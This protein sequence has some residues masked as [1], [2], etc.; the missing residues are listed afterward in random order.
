MFTYDRI[1]LPQ[2]NTAMV[3]I[4]TLVREGLLIRDLATILHGLRKVRNKA[5]HENY[6]SVT[7][8][9]NFLPM[10]YGM[11]EWFMQTYGDWSYT[12]KNFV[13]PEER[14]MAV[15]ID[16]EAEEKKEAELAKQ[17]E[18]NAAN[19]P[20]VAQEERK[21]Q[22]Y[23]V[24]NQRPKTEAETEN[25]RYS[26]GIRPTRGRKLA[27]AEYP[28]NS[29]VG[30]RGYADY[31]LFIGEKLVGIIEA[32]AIHKDI[33]SVIDYQGK[34]YPRCIREEDEKYVIGKWGD[35]RVP[36]TFATNGRPYLEQYKTKSGIWFLDLRKLDNSPM[37]LHGWMSPDGMEELLAADVDSKNK[38]LKEMPYDL[39]TDTYCGASLY[40]LRGDYNLQQKMM[41]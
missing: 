22:A 7:D 24:A 31:A 13:M 9:K 16:K 18:E 41:V 25:I 26:K 8:S 29:T 11:C 2:D 5:V 34:D 27:I 1:A 3:R 32:K 15:S 19:A 33:P 38:E 14:A 35:F 17:A 39:L 21:K 40:F 20:K 37:A 23:K 36:F 30:N 4:D 10:A 6:S 28:T 12:H